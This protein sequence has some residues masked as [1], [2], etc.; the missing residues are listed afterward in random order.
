MSLTDHHSGERFQSVRCA[1]CG[2]GYL[3][4][5][6][7]P[8]ALEHYYSTNDSGASMRRSAG[9]LFDYMRRIS[10]SRE[11]RPLRLKIEPGAPIL[12]LGTGDGAMARYLQQT[13][14][15]AAAADFYPRSEWPHDGIPYRQLDLHGGMLRPEVLAT[16]FTEVPRV[17]VMR[18]VL[19][20]LHQPRQ[21][22]TAIAAAGVEW[23]YIVVPN[24]GSAF[25]R[26]FGSNWYYWDP[27]RHIQFFERDTL[28]RICERSG[29]RMEAEGW[30]GIDEII[31]SAHR[32]A[33]LSPYLPARGAVVSLTRPKGML[34][35][36]FSALA[37]P[38]GKA[39]CW[40]IARRN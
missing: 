39:V 23:L 29:F 35:G 28:K 12:D 6:P 21:V 14:Y 20:H 25:A 13:G 27:P 36:V 19:E 16:A 18:H 2:Y 37:A 10:F 33:L 1:H 32:R 4:P 26:Q 7:P 9:A 8:G 31:T 17:A 3:D 11:T 15:R 24:C 5:A 22:L 40:I 34:A 38:W 30:Y